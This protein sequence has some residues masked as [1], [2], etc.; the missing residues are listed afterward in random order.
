MVLW[1]RVIMQPFNYILITVDKVKELVN[2]NFILSDRNYKDI[3]L[4]FEE[5]C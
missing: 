2:V 5:M 3:W 1:F 4:H